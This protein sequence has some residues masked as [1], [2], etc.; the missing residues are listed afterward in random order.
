MTEELCKC[1]KA[2][3]VYNGLCTDCLAKALSGAQKQVTSD[4]ARKVLLKEQMQR[5]QAAQAE[6]QQ[7]LDKHKVVPDVAMLL[8]PGQV[9]PQVGFAPA[10]GWAGDPGDLLRLT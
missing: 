8:R 5:V 1:G 6:V 10:E 9:I 4:E 7:V 2:P 3:A